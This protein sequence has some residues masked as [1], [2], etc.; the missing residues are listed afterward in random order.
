MRNGNLILTALERLDRSRQTRIGIDIS[1][2]ASRVM[3]KRLRDVCGLP[4]SECSGAP[5]AASSSAIAG[6]G[7]GF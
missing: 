4:E 7:V 1:P 5:D 2:T 6:E 3:A